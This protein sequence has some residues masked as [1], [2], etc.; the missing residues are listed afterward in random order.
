MLHTFSKSYK[1]SC[2][3]LYRHCSLFH[4]WFSWFLVNHPRCPNNIAALIRFPLFQHRNLDGISPYRRSSDIHYSQHMACAH[5]MAVVLLLTLQALA[6]HF[7]QLYRSPQIHTNSP[8]PSPQSDPST[9]SGPSS[10]HSIYIGNQPHPAWIGGRPRVRR[11]QVG[12]ERIMNG[13]LLTASGKER[14]NSGGG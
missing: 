10:D 6:H 1:Y 9:A 7:Y 2:M 8:H 11:S 12:D 5:S 3:R 4:I 13:L 14:R